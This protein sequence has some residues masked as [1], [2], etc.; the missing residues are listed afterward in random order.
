MFSIKF[1][2][3]NSIILIESSVGQDHIGWR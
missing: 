1:N 3:G 2:L